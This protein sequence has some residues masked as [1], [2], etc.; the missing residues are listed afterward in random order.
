MAKKR[1]VSAIKINDHFQKLAQTD[2]DLKPLWP[3]LKELGD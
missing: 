2:A 1:L 3:E